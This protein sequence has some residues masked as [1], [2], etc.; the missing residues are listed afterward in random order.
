MMKAENKPHPMPYEFACESL[1][2]DPANTVVPEDSM[3]GIASLQQPVVSW[4]QY[5][6][7]GGH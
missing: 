3:T 6:T 7:H 2:V 4:W 1:G 5:R